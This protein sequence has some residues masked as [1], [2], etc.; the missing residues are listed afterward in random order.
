MSFWDGM[1]QSRANKHF[2]ENSEI[3]YNL[4][5]CNISRDKKDMSEMKIIH[6]LEE[7]ILCCEEGMS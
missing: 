1:E 3:I 5:T 4:C 2:T 7:F 6:F